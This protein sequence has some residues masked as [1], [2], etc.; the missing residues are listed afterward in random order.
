M[1]GSRPRAASGAQGMADEEQ[2]AILRQGP[3]AWNAWRQEDCGVRADLGGADLGRADLREANL[4]RAD[5]GGADLREAD[6]GRADLRR[7]DLGRANLGRADLREANL[8]RADLR[9]TDLGGTDL[10]GAD[11]GRA[12]LRGAILH[13]ASLREAV[14]Y[15]TVLC[16]VDLSSCKG[17]ESCFHASPS[18]ID[19]RTLRRSGPLPLAFLRG[20]GLPD[21]LI[22]QLPRLFGQADQFYRCFISYSS[23]DSEFAGQRQ[24]PRSAAARPRGRGG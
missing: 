7:A 22:K 19:Y 21:N 23:Q 12:D 11:L 4:G 10:G 20:V 18:I 3:Q 8:G 13:E 6:L 17:L 5:L 2:L 15:E 9:G 14:L 1:L 16:D 24:R